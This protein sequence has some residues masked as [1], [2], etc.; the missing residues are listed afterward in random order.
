[1]D[2]YRIIK[3]EINFGKS[4]ESIESL[5]ILK[6]IFSF[7]SENQKLNIIIYNNHLQKILISILKIIKE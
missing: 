6:I 2:N 7:L 4:I 3:S 1:M 5:Y